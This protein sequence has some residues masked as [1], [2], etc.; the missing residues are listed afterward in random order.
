MSPS[1]RLV[2]LI[3][4]VLVPR[5]AGAWQVHVG[6]GYGQ[7]FASAVALDAKRNVIAAGATLYGGDT[8]SATVVKLS[9][10]GRLLWKTLVAGDGSMSVS[11]AIDAAGDVV[12]GGLEGGF[13]ESYRGH[14]TITKLDGATGA[15]V[16]R[17]AEPLSHDGVVR[18]DAAGDVVFSIFWDLVV[19]VRYTCAKLRGSDGA[20]QWRVPD[21]GMIRAGNAAGDVVVTSYGSTR[22]LLG[23]T[24]ATA[25]DQTTLDVSPRFGALDGAG[26]VL[27]ANATTLLELDG[28]TGALLWQI[29]DPTLDGRI[30]G[31][32][33]LAV[34]P[35]GDVVLGG[36]TAFQFDP[37]VG[38]DALLVKRSGADGS[39]QWRET[40]TNGVVGIE[41]VRAVAVD[42]RGNVTAA[43]R[44]VTENLGDICLVARLAGASG[45]TR[46]ARRLHHRVSYCGSIALD[47]LGNFAIGGSGL[48]PSYDLDLYGPS[49]SFVVVRGSGW[50]GQ[51]LRPVR[52]FP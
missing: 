13:D 43:I 16:W 49:A 18:L 9:R 17:H 30:A 8:G 19:D 34:D 25:W 46:W 35:A 42:R 6:T 48:P 38:N 40:F 26:N 45:K 31:I 29:V 41:L 27:L 1:R 20:E 5:L 39:E 36:M 2:L 7:D 44:L 22:K 33:S 28:T 51:G 52:V 15:V 10:N 37:Y 24:G 11:V 14:F 23:A 3:A 21:C 50:S 47:R 12:I 32:S 4:L